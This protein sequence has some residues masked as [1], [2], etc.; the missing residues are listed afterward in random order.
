M[1]V[2]EIMTSKMESAGPDLSIQEAA[3]R[4]R[5]LEIGSLPVWENGKLIGIVTD[6]DICCRAIANGLDPSKTTVRE[7]MTGEVAFCFG[8]DDIANAARLMEGKHLRRLAV[9]NHD[10]TMAG[11]LSVDDLALVSH[12][13][14]GEV[15]E[16][17]KPTH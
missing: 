12:Q 6:R 17:A 1:Q 10:R 2:K 9:L 3:R 15:L 11:F 13:L 7:I 14:A 4:M 16:A 8:D 5:D